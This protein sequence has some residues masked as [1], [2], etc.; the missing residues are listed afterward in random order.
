VHSF[1][2]AIRWFS[3]VAYDVTNHRRS[4]LF[5]AEVNSRVICGGSARRQKKS[6][7]LGSRAKSCVSDVSTISILACCGRRKSSIRGAVVRLVPFY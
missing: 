2:S 1:C 5:E 7:R 4:R 3:L 6:K